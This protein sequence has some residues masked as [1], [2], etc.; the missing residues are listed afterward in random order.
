MKYQLMT[1]ERLAAIQEG[2]NTMTRREILKH[3]NISSRTL[4]KYAIT[5]APAQDKRLA[6]VQPHQIE[7]VRELSAQGLSERAIAE[8]TGLSCRQVRR[9]KH[10]YAIPSVPLSERPRA[11]KPEKPKP[12]KKKNNGRNPMKSLQQWK[13]AVA[14]GELEEAVQRLRRTGL[15]VFSEDVVRHADKAPPR[16]SG[17]TTF[18]V[19]NRKGVTAAELVRL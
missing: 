7:Q 17:A 12:E 10:K 14:F 4:T 15:A 18:V 5:K 11:P 8:K 9:T 3:F 19:G 2:M 16:Y 1:P 6:M 13:P